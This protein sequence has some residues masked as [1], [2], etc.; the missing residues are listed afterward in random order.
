M[1]CMTFNTS[2]AR[3]NAYPVYIP[4]SEPSWKKTPYNS[5]FNKV[6]QFLLPEEFVISFKQKINNSRL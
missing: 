6:V 4:V 3:G 5:S 2:Q 1:D